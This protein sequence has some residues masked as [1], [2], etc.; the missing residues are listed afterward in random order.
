MACL[1]CM[2]ALLGYEEGAMPK[3]SSFDIPSL[4][5]LGAV[6]ISVAA[7]EAMPGGQQWKELNQYAMRVRGVINGMP[8]GT[9]A[10]SFYNALAKIEAGLKQAKG[11][12]GWMSW[13][14]Q[15]DWIGSPVLWES[16]YKQW[17]TQLAQI[18]VGLA[19]RTG[20]LTTIQTPPQQL[21]VTE[22]IQWAGDGSPYVPPPM[23]VNIVGPIGGGESP[24]V[25]PATNWFAVAVAAA[26]F[27]TAIYV[28][29]PKKGN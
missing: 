11:T 16:E 25:P 13:T 6:A 26:L 4:K 27:G 28:I 8:S 12:Y 18:E 10:E 29:W 14:R 2:L 15:P 1:P 17:K 24:Y 9:V 7:S 20:A 23:P 3:A 22:A 21:K 5:G 19:Q